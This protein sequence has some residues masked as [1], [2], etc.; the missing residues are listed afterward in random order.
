MFKSLGSVN[1]GCSKHVSYFTKLGNYWDEE[2]KGRPRKELTDDESMIKLTVKI[3]P[4]SSH[5]K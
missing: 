1:I 4:T 5:K 3:S 2:R